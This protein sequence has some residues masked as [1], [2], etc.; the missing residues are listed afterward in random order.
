MNSI[1][2]VGIDVSKESNQVHAMNYNQK[3]LLYKSFPNSESGA[4]NLE[5]VLLKLLHK[6]EFKSIQ[7][8]LETT[9]VYSAHI[10][11]Y[12]SASSKLM[13]YNVLVYLI[14][15]KISKS[16]VRVF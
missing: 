4:D 13:P 8:V 7:I 15:P 14:N 11:T 3:R 1:L 9:G 6:H 12:L 10:A 2:Y 5:D 16:I